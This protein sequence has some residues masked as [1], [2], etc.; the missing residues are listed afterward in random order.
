MCHKNKKYTFVQFKSLKDY[1]DS[2]KKFLCRTLASLIFFL[3]LGKKFM[4]ICDASDNCNITDKISD[5]VRMI[6]K[7]Y[8]SILSKGHKLKGGISFFIETVIK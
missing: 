6:D 7:D 2:F 8:I 1:Q 5:R 3:L 4:H